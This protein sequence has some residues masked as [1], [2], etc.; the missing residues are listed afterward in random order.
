LLFEN[1]M[2]HVGSYQ[3]KSNGCEQQYY[4]RE[5]QSSCYLCATVPE[6][7]RTCSNKARQAITVAKTTCQKSP[8]KQAA[9]ADD[10]SANGSKKHSML[11]PRLG[12]AA[13][14]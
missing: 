13:A 8:A 11:L 5:V 3:E 7:L 12:G 6:C 4:Y 9:T 14:T 10:Q 2:C 1:S